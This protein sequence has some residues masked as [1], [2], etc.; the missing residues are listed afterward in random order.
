MENPP[1][2]RFLAFPWPFWL[3][4]SM[5]PISVG[6]FVRIPCSNLVT[7]QNRCRPVS[8]IYGR[9]HQDVYETFTDPYQSYQLMTGQIPP[10]SALTRAVRRLPNPPTAF[11][12]LQM[13]LLLLKTRKTNTLEHFWP[14]WKLPIHGKISKISLGIR[15]PRWSEMCWNHLWKLCKKSRNKVVRV[16]RIFCRNFPLKK[17]VLCSNIVKIN[18]A[19]CEITQVRIPPRIENPVC[20]T[21]STIDC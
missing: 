17:S 3:I 21:Q 7:H 8:E 20:H 12:R 6:R 5:I 10:G 4:I 15:H 11:L 16:S 13:D 18:S 19:T 14:I 2:D 1:D 9:F